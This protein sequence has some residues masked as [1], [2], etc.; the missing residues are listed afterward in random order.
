MNKLH[1]KTAVI[2]GGSSGIG[3]ATARLFLREGARVILAARSQETIAQAL[4]L[5]ES[6]G[7][8]TGIAIGFRCD[9][10]NLRELDRLVEYAQQQFGKLDIFF[11]NAGVNELASFGSVSEEAFDRQFDINVKGLF[12]SVQKALSIISDGGSI[13]L[14]GSIAST[15]VL[16]GHNVY[17]ATK[18]ALRAFA[19]NWAVDLKGRKIRVNLLSPGPVRTPI[20]EKMGLT[21]AELAEIDGGI[22]NLVPLGRWGMP[23][24]LANAALFLACDDSSFVTGTELQVDGGSGQT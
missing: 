10:A 24:D 14:T 8:G 9:V 3:L 6:E 12:F 17:A 2:T 22:G 20:L 18:A 15:R 1:G 13:I 4:K 7:H 19:R 23:E 5:L 11:A 21:G 16:P